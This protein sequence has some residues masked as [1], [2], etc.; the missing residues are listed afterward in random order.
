MHTLQVQDLHAVTPAF[1]LEASG[2]ILHSLSYQQARN[3]RLAVGQVYLAEGGFL[4]GQAGVPKHSIITSL[5]GVDTPDMASFTAVLCGLP[6]GSRPTL[7]YFTM[8]ERHRRQ[9]TILRL[10]YTWYAVSHNANMAKVCMAPSI[11]HMLF[12]LCIRTRG[13]PLKA[14]QLHHV[15]QPYT[16]AKQTRSAHISS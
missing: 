2:S 6:T 14:Q 4:M 11:C 13:I 1:F 8:T 3:N 7:Q 16:V 15:M 10:D 9:S 12:W 5:N